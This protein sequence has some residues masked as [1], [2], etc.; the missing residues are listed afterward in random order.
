MKPIFLLLTIC[1]CWTPLYIYA[2]EEEEEENLEETDTMDQQNNGDKTEPFISDKEINDLLDGTRSSDNATTASTPS[3]PQSSGSSS[4]NNN[5]PASSGDG[6]GQW[7]GTTVTPLEDDGF[8]VTDSNGNTVTYPGN[9]S[10]PV[11]PSADTEASGIA[12][13]IPPDIHNP[14]YVSDTP[15]ADP[16][17][18]DDRARINQEWDE[19]KNEVY[20]EQTP[21]DVPLSAESPDSSSS[22]WPAPVTP[23]GESYSSFTPPDEDFN[24]L[25]PF[26]S[27][28]SVDWK[29]TPLGDP[30]TD[31]KALDAVLGGKLVGHGQDI[32][33]AGLKHG[34]DPGLLASIAMHESAGGSRMPTNNPL[35]IIDG[36]GGYKTF[37]TMAD[38]FDYIAD[39]IANH[40]NYEAARQA[41]T[42]Q[43]LGRTYAEDPDWHTAV[44]KW[45]NKIRGS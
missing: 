1:L 37:N 35:G 26:S 6:S 30:I 31:A 43:R 13:D 18:E 21:S 28:E 23:D 17:T 36:N 19:M 25:D 44:T 20:G 16:V 4:D 11:V 7:P 5:A 2:E 27:P 29:M 8:S 3:S 39:R 42:I 12:D 38:S 33:N 22:E 10:E 45:Y 40:K 32:V 24:N 9:G 34:V 15:N 41:G 14:T